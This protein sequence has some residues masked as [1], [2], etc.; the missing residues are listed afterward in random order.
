MVENGRN[1]KF[2]HNPWF[3]NQ[4][5]PLLELPLL[6]HSFLHPWHHL[7]EDIKCPN[8]SHS[9]IDCAKIPVDSYV[10]CLTYCLSPVSCYCHK[11]D[12][13]SGQCP[14]N[15]LGIILDLCDSVTDSGY[16]CYPLYY[17]TLCLST[18]ALWWYP[19][20]TGVSYTLITNQWTILWLCTTVFDKYEDWFC[21]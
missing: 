4:S 1:L 8:C 13:S 15:G 11:Q 9:P 3:Y 5:I 21:L 14:S 18:E 7:H 10:H 19:C 12:R 20:S 17:C 2:C 6:I 16:L